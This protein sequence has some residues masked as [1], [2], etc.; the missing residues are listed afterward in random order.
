MPRID[1]GL[2]A[3]TP[4]KLRRTPCTAVNPSSGRVT[5][6]AA[7]AWIDH[8]AGNSIRLSRSRGADPGSSAKHTREIH[9]RNGIIDSCLESSLQ[10]VFNRPM[11]AGK[12]ESLRI[13]VKSD[14]NVTVDTRVIQF[15][16]GEVNRL[17]KRYG[18]RLTR[19]EVHLSD[20]N[21]RKFG[22]S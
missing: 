3:F 16:R 13:Q 6:L 19:V 21:S 10:E 20:V 11:K 12:E 2:P 7:S 4:K 22:K 15:V 17:L 9:P 1:S 18:S 5:P 8:S 14:K